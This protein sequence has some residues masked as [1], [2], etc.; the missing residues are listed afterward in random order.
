[1]GLLVVLACLAA[2]SLFFYFRQNF[3]GQIGGRMSLP[4]LFWLNYALVSW[5]VMP[6]WLR[7]SRRIVPAI[8]WIYG[9]LLFS[10]VLRGVGEVYLLYVT[11]SWIPPYG[12]AHDLLTLLFVIFTMG[13]A[14]KPARAAGDPANR[15]A[16]QFLAAVCAGLACEVGFA[17]LFYQSVGYETSRTWFASSAPRFA[18]IN[19]LT[20]TV[21]IVAYG[22]LFRTLWTAREALF[23]RVLPDGE[24][25]DG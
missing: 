25:R 18:L 11:H 21:V 2:A 9:G 19:G 14:R 10:F 4:K 17:W 1:M 12:I 13:R 20:W 16:F 22:N 23:P 15:A 6:F 3:G 7:R 8:R 24:A 5:F